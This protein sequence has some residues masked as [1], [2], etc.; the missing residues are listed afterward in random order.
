MRK[1]LIQLNTRINQ[2]SVGD[3]GKNVEKL[4]DEK[5]GKQKRKS[6]AFIEEAITS[7]NNHYLWWC[8]ELLPAALGGEAPLAKVV[9]Q[10]LLNHHLP[11]NPNKLN[12]IDAEYFSQDHNRHIDLLNFARFVRENYTSESEMEEAT[13]K[14][15]AQVVSTGVD[16]WRDDNAISTQKNDSAVA[17]LWDHFCSCYLP[18]ASNSQF[19]EAGVKEARIVSTTGKKLRALLR[20]CHLPVFFVWKSEAFDKHSSKSPPNL[21]CDHW[22]K[23]DPSEWSHQACEKREMETSDECSPQKPFPKREVGEETEEHL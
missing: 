17:K 10:I 2:N 13:I 12:Q 6:K 19:V 20:L 22:T 9:A 21:D 4:S 1:D 18:F 5:E 11:D 14:Q 16:I 3:Y 8:N 15:L 23:L 7:L